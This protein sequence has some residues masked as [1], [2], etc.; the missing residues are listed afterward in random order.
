[1]GKNR[2]FYLAALFGCTVLYLAYREWLAWFLLVTAITLPFFSL[3]TVLPAV[4]FYRPAVLLP[5]AVEQ[6][7]AVS[8]ALSNTKWFYPPLLHSCIHVSNSF[9]GLSRQLTDGQLLP[10]EHCGMLRIEMMQLRIF[11][12]LGLFALPLFR[13]RNTTIPVRP[14]EL[15]MANPPHPNSSLSSAWVVKRNGSAEEHELRNYRPGDELR[16]IHWKLSAKTGKTIVREGV[17]PRQDMAGICLELSGSADEIDRKLGRA[18]WL[19]RHLL[20]QGTAHELRCLSGRGFERFSISSAEDAVS[21]LDAL[22]ASPPAPPEARFENSSAGWFF[23]IGGD[24]NE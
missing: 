21:A 15:P 14:A 1:M 24:E 20:S 23:F 4:L 19:S 11:D 5:T 7:S 17:E 2:L 3:L 10:T 6:G 16:M 18:L 22:L 8:L 12:P 9:S 13:A